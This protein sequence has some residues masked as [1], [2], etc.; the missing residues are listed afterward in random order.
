MGA[1]D[2][3]SQHAAPDSLLNQDETKMTNNEKTQLRL[4]AQTNHDEHRKRLPKP[5][6]PLLILVVQVL[7]SGATWVSSLVVLAALKK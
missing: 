6:I 1:S 3:W 4:D 7:T 5:L 2:P